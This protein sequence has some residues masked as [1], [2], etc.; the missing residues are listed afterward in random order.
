M[1]KAR[2]GIAVLVVAPV[3][4]S[5]A[6]A[7]AAVA[8]ISAEVMAEA[9]ATALAACISAVATTPV[10]GSA[11]HIHFREGAFAAAVLLPVEA[12][13]TSARSETPRCDPEASAAL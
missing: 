8:D 10:R 3:L 12:G 9:G 11:S 7:T 4:S 6:V 5:A 2:I 13:G 1:S